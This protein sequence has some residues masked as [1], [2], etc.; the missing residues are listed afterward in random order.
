MEVEFLSN[1]RYALLASK[2][3]WEEWLGKLTAYFEFW[4]RVTRPVS[5]A[6][7]PSPTLVIPSPG[8]GRGYSPLPSPT[9]LQ[10][11][12]GLSASRPTR[13]SPP[14]QT[15]NNTSNPSLFTFSNGGN[16]VSP[17]ANRSDL[18]NNRK[19]SW[20]EN[21][22]DLPVKRAYRAPSQA[23]APLP[24]SSSIYSKPDPRRLPVPNLTLNTTHHAPTTQPQYASTY[25]MPQAATMSLPPL[26][27]GIRAMATVYAPSTSNSWVPPAAG[28]SGASQ[29]SV[30]APTT[31]NTPISQYPPTSTPGYGTPTK[32]RSPVNTLTPANA[33]NTSSPMHDQFPP[34]NGFS[35]PISLS[36]SVYLQ[37]RTSPYRPIRHVHTLLNPPPSAS[38]QSYH[39]PAIAPN[40]MHY[41]PIGRR[42]DYRT[43]IVPEYRNQGY[44]AGNSQNEGL[45]PNT[46]VP[47]QQRYPD[48][49]N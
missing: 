32:R 9:A 28:G 34:N 35:T 43:G 36:P 7:A 41:Q 17:L 19:R 24:S 16:N 26:D 42:D 33:Y 22:D 47:S 40:Q 31:L 4:D 6:V 45:A 44:Y 21:A 8:V 20:D 10:A 27:P 29:S 12:H 37:Q 25:S 39:L 1:M 30:P 38:L 49:V 2:E 3:Q 15:P 5:P 18:G 48:L 11:A 23:A 14:A 46:S 13:Y